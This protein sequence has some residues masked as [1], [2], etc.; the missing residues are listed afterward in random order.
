MGGVDFYLLWMVCTQIWW[1]C[2]PLDRNQITAA[3][4]IGDP[5]VK[6]YIYKQHWKKT[7]DRIFSIGD[8]SL[9]FPSSKPLPLQKRVRLHHH[10]ATAQDIMASDVIRFS[11]LYVANHLM[12][13]LPPGVRRVRL[14]QDQGVDI[15]VVVI[16]KFR[17]PDV[18]VLIV[19]LDVDG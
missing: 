6:A 7:N 4:S 9:S 14:G 19:D 1:F 18:D 16:S 10:R 17:A 12:M 15:R 13:L 11:V 3:I 5:G 2:L 8:L